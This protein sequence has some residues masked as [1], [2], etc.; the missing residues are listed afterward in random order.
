M[1]G[2]HASA[3]EN[4]AVKPDTP[5][6]PTQPENTTPEIRTI[7][8]NAETGD[9]IAYAG[10]RLTII[11]TVQ[12]SGLR[13][14]QEYK[15]KG[16]LM[17]KAAGKP[18]LVQG[19]KVTAETAF[20]PT[21]PNGTVDVEFI[22]D[23]SALAGK[24]IVVFE[25]LFWIKTDAEGNPSEE[26]VASHEDIEDEGQTVTIREIPETP[27]T[28]QPPQEPQK[29][30]EPQE[31]PKTGDTGPVLLY[32]FLMGLSACAA[33]VLCRRTRPRKTER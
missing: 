25:Q 28:P 18:L 19:K 15:V 24:D 30:E 8:K 20:R 6:N 17:D 7:A 22:L 1:D 12:F 9:H 32:S 31:V 5:Q 13:V 11:D 4:D 33:A 29:P 16:I 23:G 27:E 14:G 10:K 21:A 26:K 3:V 2:L